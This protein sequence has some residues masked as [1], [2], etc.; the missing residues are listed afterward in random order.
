MKRN[1][2]RLARPSIRQYPH[3]RKIAA[4]VVGYQEPLPAAVHAEMTRRRPARGRLAKELQFPLA[5]NRETAHRT[6]PL[7]IYRIQKRARRVPRQERWVCCCRR[8]SQFAELPRLRVKERG[9]DPAAVRVRI[10]VRT[11]E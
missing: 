9:I 4:V 11:D 3:H 1:H 5:A 10:G 2:P 6:L 8:R 7:F